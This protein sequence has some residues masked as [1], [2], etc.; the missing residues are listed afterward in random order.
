[1]TMTLHLGSAY[2][3]NLNLTSEAGNR[4]KLTVDQRL[5]KHKVYSCVGPELC[6]T[7]E[8]KLPNPF[9]KHTDKD[10]VSSVR[11]PPCLTCNGVT[12]V[13]KQAF[14]HLIRIH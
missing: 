13:E 10:T 7:T 4:A 2:L 5:A 11:A 3:T 12:H 1:M 14:V 9:I 8:E 6:I